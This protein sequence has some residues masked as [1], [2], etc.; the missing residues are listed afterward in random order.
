MLFSTVF[1]LFPSISTYPDICFCDFLLVS[2]NISNF[3]NPSVDIHAKCTMN[4]VNIRTIDNNTINYS[5]ISAQYRS[6]IQ[7]PGSR[8]PD[9]EST[10]DPGEIVQADYSWL[11]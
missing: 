2:T 10:Q 11:L 1:L 7:D 3:S 5:S 6:W 8:M 9:P 4:Y